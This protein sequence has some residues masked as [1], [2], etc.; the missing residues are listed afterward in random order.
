MSDLANNQHFR[1]AIVAALERE[2]RP[3]TRDW[4]VREKEYSGHAFRFFENGDTVLVCG[5]IGPEAARRATQA[6]IA[7][8]SPQLIYSAGFAGAANKAMKV[9]EILTPRRVVNANDGSSVDTGIG[10]GVLVSFTAVASPEQKAKLAASFGAHAVDMEAAAVAQAAQA[11][12]V[13]FAAVKAISDE[14]DFEF[15][16]MDAFISPAGQLYTVKLAFFLAVRPWLWATAFRLAR[17][18]SQ[19]SRALSTHL[20]HM[21]ESQTIQPAPAPHPTSLE[22]STRR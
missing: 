15:P 14:I 11:P 5:G 22:T 18:S 13:T 1:I 4:A 8:Y 16:P 7:L 12:G 10:E 3:L 20:K 17:N 2:V 9:G 6:V 19:A 21:I